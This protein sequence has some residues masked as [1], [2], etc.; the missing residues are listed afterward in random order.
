MANGYT[1]NYGLC[2]W[3]PGDKFLRE[4]FNQDNAKLD[5]AL[6]AS[7]E[8]A[9]AEAQTAQSTAER[10][11]AG[12]EA[13]DYNIYN[14]L[15]Q[16]EYEG[17]YTGYKKALLYDGFSDESRIASK[18][19]TIQIKNK[20]ARLSKTGQGNITSAK[21]GGT[22]FL[23]DA[24]CSTDTYTATGAGTLTGITF[25]FTPTDSFGCTTYLN[26]TH[27]GESVG[28]QQVTFESGTSGTKT[29]ML[30]TAVELVRGDTFSLSL[31]SNSSSRSVNIWL[32]TNGHIAGTILV[33]ALGAA[34]GTLTAKTAELEGTREK[35]MIFVRYS[36]GT[37][38][39]KLNGAALSRTARRTTVEVGGRSCTED[40]Y[41]GNWSGGSLSVSFTLSCGSDSECVFYTYGVVL[42]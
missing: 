21:G 26:V 40:T 36:G 19:T 5:A 9:A 32:N 15:L 25:E 23:G 18:S 11:L 37:V 34:S 6:K 7:E 12:L 38:T 33:T 30:N 3:Q 10:A 8:K 29:V 39:P 27:N 13:A 4:E 41:E 17:K 1:A 35:A 28:R 31:D 20:A 42:I 22:C 14:L 24:S 16:N 2:Q